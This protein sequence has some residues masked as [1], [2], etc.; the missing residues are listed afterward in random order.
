M[1]QSKPANTGTGASSSFAVLRAVG[2]VISAVTFVIAMG[3]SCQE[4]D[5]GKEPVV[6]LADHPRI[7]VAIE[8]AYDTAAPFSEGLALVST[9]SNKTRS[10]QYIDQAGKTVIESKPDWHLAGP[11]REGL[12]AV[13]VTRSKPTLGLGF[14]F[15]EQSFGRGEVPAE[16]TTLKELESWLEQLVEVPAEELRKAERAYKD[17]GGRGGYDTRSENSFDRRSPRER[18]KEMLSHNRARIGFAALAALARSQWGYIDTRGNWVLSPRWDVAE[19]FQNGA[20]RVGQR[21]PLV[22]GAELAAPKQELVPIPFKPKK[23]VRPSEQATLHTGVRNLE[24]VEQRLAAMF[25]LSHLH[26]A[27]KISSLLP[28]EQ[29]LAKEALQLVHWYG[30]DYL[31]N[32]DLGGLGATLEHYSVSRRQL[33][34]VPQKLPP[35]DESTNKP[36]P[37]HNDKATNPFAGQWE[38]ARPFSQG[39]AAVKRDGMWGYINESG[40]LVIEVKWDEAQPFA[41]GMAAVRLGDK[42]GYLKIVQP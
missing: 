38:E 16:F 20:A 34:G 9:R 40:E 29:R 8:P 1:N 3:M 5:T 15:L 2:Y 33:D 21:R 37:S 4:A 36:P 25:G 6:K 31:P 18:D 13:G 42:W 27:K 19:P 24:N 17:G 7:V 26:S 32:A 28:E 22:S 39:A 10:W 14:G 11:F 35:R 23:V 41:E 12:A 30:N